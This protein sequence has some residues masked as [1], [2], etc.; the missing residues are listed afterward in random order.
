MGRGIM[1][2]LWF[3]VYQ[4]MLKRRLALLPKCH[5]SKYL[6]EIVADMVI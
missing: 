2:R 6:L 5:S 1:P 3:S 4:R